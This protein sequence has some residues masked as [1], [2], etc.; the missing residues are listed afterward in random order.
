M[1]RWISTALVLESSHISFQKCM[2]INE[3][4]CLCDKI[5]ALWLTTFFNIFASTRQFGRTLRYKLY[6]VESFQDINVTHT[7][8][9]NE[10]AL[11]KEYSILSVYYYFQ[12]IVNILPTIFFLII[13]PLKRLS[14][15]SKEFYILS[16]TEF[17]LANYSTYIYITCTRTFHAS[18]NRKMLQ[19]LW[20]LNTLVWHLI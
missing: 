17:Y 19:P 14:N 5:R 1:I 3:I 8:D 7:V 2:R 4:K 10:T 20:K 15:G 11:T 16:Y 18:A 13:I 9:S 6:W 12:K